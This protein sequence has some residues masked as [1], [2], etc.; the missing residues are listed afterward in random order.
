M[1]KLKF[2][3]LISSVLFMT[4]LVF[5]PSTILVTSSNIY[6]IH[7]L[8][9]TSTNWAGYAVETNL[10]TP[11]NGAITDVKG[12]WIV[13]TVL[14]SVTPNTYSASWIGIDGYSSNS[15]EQ[16]GTDSNV[17][18]GIAEYAAWYEM[19]PNAPVY[20]GMTINAGDTISAEVNYLGLGIFRLSITDVTT[21]ASF[22]TIQISSDAATRVFSNPVISGGTEHVFV[23]NTRLLTIMGRTTITTTYDTYHNVRYTTSV[24]VTVPADEGRLSGAPHRSSA[25]WIIEAPTNLNGDVLPLADFGTAYFFNSQV[26]V[27]GVIGSINNAHWQNDAITMQTSTPS[28]II[29]ARPS[30]LSTDGTSFSVT[31]Q[32][33]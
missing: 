21:G 22:S 19:F 23:G 18:N 14:G 12:S 4:V 17:N 3:L 13:P 26:T 28:S 8:Q 11:Q 7:T 24:P 32:H 27:N 1:T 29:K 5:S 31:W 2:V 20:L 16:I 15:V 9:G 33:Q 10:N 25:E 6:N 30:H